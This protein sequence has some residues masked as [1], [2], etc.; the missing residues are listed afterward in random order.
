VGDIVGLGHNFEADGNLGGLAGPKPSKS[1]I[2]D[3]RGSLT[4]EK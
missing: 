2:L 1:E 4:G 3:I